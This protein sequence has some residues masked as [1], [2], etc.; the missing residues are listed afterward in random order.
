MQTLYFYNPDTKLFTHSKLIHNGVL[1]PNS[2]TQVPDTSLKNPMFIQGGWFEYIPGYTR[3]APVILTRLQ[4]MN[5]FTDVELTA[6]LTAA[7]TDVAIELW[8]KK[9]DAAT[10]INL[11]DPNLIIGV[12]NLETSTL[13]GVGR[14]SEILAPGTN[15]NNLTI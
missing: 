5:R 8:V 7:K 11:S 9:L 6:I 2:T 4:F 13:I 12:N 3:V 1:Y 15:S 10:D 14:A